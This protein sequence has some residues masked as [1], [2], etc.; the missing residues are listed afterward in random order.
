MTKTF[1]IAILTVCLFACKNRPADNTDSLNKINQND[2]ID[3]KLNQTENFDDFISKF[4][5]DT[6]FMRTRLILPLKGKLTTLVDG[7][8]QKTQ[9]W[10]DIKMRYIGSFDE[11]V[12]EAKD[13]DLKHKFEKYL[14]KIIERI[15]VENSG[16]SVERVFE[17]KNNKWFMTEYYVTYI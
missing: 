15:F 13:M 14:N 12:K 5:S 10:T 8:E 16:F 1:L 7:M 11:V 17:L 2:S 9:D 4:Y 6:V 3:N